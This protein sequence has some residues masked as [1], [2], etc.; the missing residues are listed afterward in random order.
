MEEDGYLVKLYK[1]QTKKTK[2]M[3][4]IKVLVLS[5]SR[6][7]RGGIGAVIEAYQKTEL[8]HKYHCRWIATHRDRGSIIKLWYA[9]T[10]LVQYIAL[11]PYYDVVH[12]H[13][14]SC[15]SALRKSIF[16]Y[17]A[18]VFHKKVVAHFH[19][20]SIHD[21]LGG[22]YKGVYKFLFSSADVIIVLSD[23]WKKAVAEY[24][25]DD[26]ISNKIRVLYNP[27]VQVKHK[28][29]EKAVAK[30]KYILYAGNVETRKGYFDLLKGFAMI[31]SRHPDWNL[32]FAG[33]GDIEKGK[34]LSEELGISDRV[35]WLGWVSGSD[36]DSAFCQASVFCL[37]S[38]AEGFPMGVLD[39]W[40][41]GIP[42]VVTPVGGLPDIVVDGENA[43]VFP[44]GD[45]DKLAA[46]LDR[47]I[48]DNGLREKI[49]Q[50]SLTLARTTFNIENINRKLGEIYDSLG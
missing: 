36:K 47:M 2:L 20:Y 45:V 7:T 3:K 15:Q 38:Y 30:K 6:K 50:A 17:I 28:A 9:V 44:V 40:A 4:S 26:I 42:C 24:Y 10:A 21:T 31:S 33:N 22:K 35:K 11:L 32:V 18:K 46:Q 14:S 13:F 25:K 39:A 41:Y 16:V 29:N 43:L 27:C 48:N 12:V 34:K 37:P 49:A 5:T 23:L 19:A 8:W 1:I